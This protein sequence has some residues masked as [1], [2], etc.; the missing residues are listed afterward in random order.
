MNGKNLKLQIWDTAGQE[1]FKNVNQTY[2]KG[3]VAV[4]L[5]YSIDNEASFEG[6]ESWIKQ[7]NEN[8]DREIVKLLV[9]C[10]SDLEYN[11]K[12]QTSQGKNM[13]SQNGMDFYEVSAKDGTNVIT[14]F[15]VLGEKVMQILQKR[16]KSK[17]HDGNRI[18]LDQKNHVKKEKWKC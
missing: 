4:I 17:E 6:I 3:A 18:S 14:A 16:S 13:A 10:K 11:R 8:S 2:F 7:I 5:A 12:V 15:Q 9:A 1:R